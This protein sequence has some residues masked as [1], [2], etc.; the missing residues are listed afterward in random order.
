MRP[1]Q[2]IADEL[3]ALP[4]QAFTAT[5]DGYI[6]EAK[7]AGERDTAAALAAMKRP[8]VSAWLV[9]LVALHHPDAIA[10]LIDLGATIRHAQ[11]S[12]TPTQLRDLSAQRRKEIDKVLA[13]AQSL[14]SGTEAA[15]GKQHVTEAESTLAAAMA[16]DE[17]ARLVRSGRVVKGLSYSGFGAAAAGLVRPSRASSA[18]AA[19]AG[20]TAVDDE[21][22]RSA[23]SA[24]VGD[25]QRVLDDA[26]AAERE[27]TDTVDQI[28]SGIAELRERLEPAQREARAARQS[29]LAAE[30]ELASA[31]RRLRS[32]EK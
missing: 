1:V 9:N 5:R 3:Y 30:R 29:R 21:F 19:A 24:R 2:E 23:A 28:V 22:R 14:A 13:L 6:A 31:E 27:A 18:S 11:G 7:L 10:Q 25:A 32:I 8:T 17:A 12:V 20:S 16:D 26:I 4:P 15:P